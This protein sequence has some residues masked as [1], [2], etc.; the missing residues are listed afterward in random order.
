MAK[1]KRLHFG[2][3]TSQ[4]RR[5]IRRLVKKHQEMKKRKAEVKENQWK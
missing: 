4:G 1:L 2:F 3:E 5:E